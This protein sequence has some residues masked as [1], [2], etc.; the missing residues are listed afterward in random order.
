MHTASKQLKRDRYIWYQ[1]HALVK[2]VGPTH[3]D[4]CAHKGW[5]VETK[6]GACNPWNPTSLGEAHENVLIRSELP[7]MCRGIFPYFCVLQERTKSWEYRLQSEQHLAH[8]QLA[9]LDMQWDMIP[10]AYVAE[11]NPSIPY[12]QCT[13]VT[14]N[15][16]YTTQ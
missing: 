9:W 2:I 4:V 13:R 1:N 3:K 11:E 6:Q 15:N 5:I 8:L 16:F 10:H 14:E 12:K 7:L